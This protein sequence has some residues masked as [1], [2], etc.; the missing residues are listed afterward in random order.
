[1]S[2]R[3]AAW[4]AWS[5]CLLCVGLAVGAL[6][7]WLLNGRSLIGFVREGDAA[8]AVLVVSFSVVGALIVSHRPENTIG[9]V[10]C[11]AALCQGLSEFGLEYATYALITRSGSLPL[12]AEMSWL[13]E[14]IWAP[15]LGLI[16]VF[17][18][19]LFPDGRPPSRRWRPVA[20]LGGLSIILIW[21]PI[22]ILI[23][24]ERGTALLRG[25]ETG[26]ERPGW[27]QALA[28]AGFPLML[29][30][31]LLAVISLFVRFHRAR[32][33]ERQ[34]I[35]WFASAAALTFAWIF[36]FEQLL[37][38]EGGV[39]EAIAAVSSLVLV[40]S[41]PIATGIAIL[42]HRLYD[43]DVLINRTLVYGALTAALALTYFG[44]V[45]TTQTIF[46][47]L[48]GQEQQPQLA[49]V[50]STLVI[51]ALFN[52]LRRRIQGF[53]DRRFY[54]RKYDAR[55]TLEAFSAKLRDDTDLDA[56]SDDLVGVVRDTMQPAHVS[57]WLRPDSARKGKGF[58]NSP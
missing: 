10:F 23:W 13:A 36:V 6:L 37:S 3:T 19:I 28:E 39:L 17:L 40:P 7:L 55:K 27:L 18:P 52:P 25:G 4:L 34:Q 26:D 1:M 45:A 2:R 14:W 42:R 32:G 48:T 44:G 57:L 35:K 8:V 9:W 43:I 11:T 29:V 49:I 5:V 24:P 51:A 56:L 30:A 20:W 16:L 38:A 46:H 58:G 53:I 33:S 15:G 47:A 12:A 41:I 54:R 22:S 50:V 21:V 31:G